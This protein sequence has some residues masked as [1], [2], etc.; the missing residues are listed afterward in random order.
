MVQIGRSGTYGLYPGRIEDMRHVVWHVEESPHNICMQF[1]IAL[2]EEFNQLSRNFFPFFCQ[3]GGGR[4]IP[5]SKLQL[6]QRTFTLNVGYLLNMPNIVLYLVNEDGF[7]MEER[8]FWWLHHVFQ[9]PYSTLVIWDKLQFSLLHIFAIR[10]F[11]SII[12]TIYVILR[13][14]KYLKR[15][16]L[17][18]IK[19]IY[20]KF[21]I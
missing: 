14:E 12:Y 9:Q 15:L 5:L 8:T 13:R 16:V 1:C 17:N 20:I 10:K 18:S 19:E 4:I 11:L 7:A 3:V 2:C 6:R 21:K